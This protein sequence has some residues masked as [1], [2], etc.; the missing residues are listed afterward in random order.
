MRKKNHPRKRILTTALLLFTGFFSALAITSCSG[1]G[2]DYSDNYIEGLLDLESSS[3][4]VKE[5]SSSSNRSSSPYSSVSYSSSSYRYSSSY[6]A[7][8]SRGDNNT[9]GVKSVKDLA[10]SCTA[11]QKIYVRNDSADYRCAYGMWFKEVSRL[12]E[13]TDTTENST[14]YRTSPYLCKFGKWVQLD[15]LDSTLGLCTTA[16]LD[17][18]KIYEDSHYRC[19]S[20]GWKRL[21]LSDV[22]GDCVQKK[23]GDS[24]TFE[25]SAYVCRNNSWS[26]LSGIEQDMGVC[27]Q[28]RLGNV[29]NYKG[30]YYVCEDYK[31]A[32]TTD[33]QTILG[34]CTAARKDSVV[35]LGSS[36][37]VC[38]SKT[39]REMSSSEIRHGVCSED[40][41]G[42]TITVSRTSH[43]I[44]D[45]HDWREATPK[46][47]YGA[48]TKALQDTLYYMD[49]SP[50]ACLDLKWTLLP[51]P[52]KNQEYCLKKNE[53]SKFTTSSPKTYM[54]CHRYAWTEVDS[55]TYVF[56]ICDMDNLA[57]K[58][59]LHKDSLLYEC[60]E[61]A[62]GAYRWTKMT[63]AEEHGK[64]TGANQDE[65]YKGYVCDNGSWRTQLSLEKS[66]GKICTQTNLGK[67]AKKSYSYYECTS[68]GWKS[69]TEKDYYLGECGPA[70][71]SLVGIYNGTEYLCSEG[72]WITPSLSADISTSSCSYYD[73]GKLGKYN[74]KI[75]ICPAQVGL[76]WQ[77]VGEIAQKYGTCNGQRENAVVTYKDSYYTCT[78]NLTWRKSH[79]PEILQSSPC[80][81]KS[82][83]G[84]QYTCSNGS[85]TPVYGTFTDTRNNKTYKT[86]VID[87]QTWMAENLNYETANSWCFMN[88]NDNCG[89][90]GRLY[91]WENVKTACPTGWHVPTKEE[92]EAM[93]TNA[94]RIEIASD[95]DSWQETPFGRQNSEYFVPGLELKGTGIRQ[96]NGVFEYDHRVGALWLADSANADSAYYARRYTQTASNDMNQWK[97]YQDMSYGFSIRCVKDN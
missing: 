49:S 10:D 56:G 43:L 61:T 20:L 93:S 58:K 90:L 16:K 64:C 87:G 40:N 73:R 32:L 67:K 37:Y 23:Y 39:W 74:N 70:T 54:I 86:I 71:D 52:P 62:T 35:V 97:S 6:S 68:D 7:Y 50:Y 38:E 46:E 96:L 36:H 66:L 44:C 47:F 28:T 75:Y 45:K 34:K 12:P 81:G 65:I 11:G 84:Q 4:S 1:Y 55:V 14:L 19:D 21:G 72:E 33:V 42:K 82:V 5:Y 63:V 3:S 57:Q 13:C 94:L 92:F 24:V 30:D 8:S 78:P 9:D 76:Q 77:Y 15:D 17:K 88:V 51:Q 18:K 69:I 29:V 91:T 60:R 59:S 85:W 41:Q 22:Y 25:G 26:R 89:K 53:G 95:D 2:S 48:C 31:W 83:C 79:L 27:A 80:S